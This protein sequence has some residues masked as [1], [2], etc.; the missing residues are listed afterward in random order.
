MQQVLLPIINN[1]VCQAAVADSVKQICAGYDQERKNMCQ[2]D[3]G[4]P[5]FILKDDGVFELIGIASFNSY[6]EQTNVPGMYIMK[7]LYTRNSPL[8]LFPLNFLLSNYENK[9]I[10]STT[11][12]NE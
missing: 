4:G 1:R 7:L 9:L 2:G 6:C 10:K 11:T 5:L 12:I 3:S 8:G